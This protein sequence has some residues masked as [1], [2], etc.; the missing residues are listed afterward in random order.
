MNPCYNCQHFRAANLRFKEPE[1]CAMSPYKVVQ[2][3]SPQMC[4]EYS[5]E[6]GTDYS[7]QFDDV[8]DYGVGDD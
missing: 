4:K 8:E 7:T 5:S 3:L 2:W 6:A 1:R